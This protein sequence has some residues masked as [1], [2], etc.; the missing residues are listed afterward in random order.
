MYQSIHHDINPH[1]LRISLFMCCVCDQHTACRSVPV[2][3]NDRESLTAAIFSALFPQGFLC[4]QQ[5]SYFF[6]DVCN[7]HWLLTYIQN[8]LSTSCFICPVKTL[9]IRYLDKSVL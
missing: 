4:L 5:F 8:F 9:Y 6:S 2:R 3:S 1:C 7:D